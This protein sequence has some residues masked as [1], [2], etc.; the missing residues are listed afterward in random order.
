VNGF[1]PSYPQKEHQMRL[2]NKPY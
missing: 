1:N 2:I